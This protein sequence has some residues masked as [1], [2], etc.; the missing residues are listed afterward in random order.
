MLLT[1]APVLIDATVS[2]TFLETA[3]RLTLSFVRALQAATSDQGAQTKPS[4]E[5][6]VKQLREAAEPLLSALSRDQLAA[7][8]SGEG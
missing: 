7:V 2:R 5:D 8:S 4:L 6:G 3:Q 1:S